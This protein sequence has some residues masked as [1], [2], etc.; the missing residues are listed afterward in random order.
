MAE[1][2]LLKARRART[3]ARTGSSSSPRGGTACAL[4]SDARLRRR[5]R[6]RA[7]GRDAAAWRALPRFEGRSSVRTWLYRVATNAWLDV[8]AKR[9]PAAADKRVDAAEVHAVPAAAGSRCGSSRIRTPSSSSR[10]GRGTGGPLRAPRE[11]RARVRRR[12]AAAPPASGGAAVARRARFSAREVAERLDMSVASANSAL[13]RARRRW[14]A[15]CPRRASRAP[16]ARSGTRG[17]PAGRAARRCDGRSDV[18]AVVAELTR[19]RPGRCRLTRLVPR[20]GARPSWSSRRSSMARPARQA[21]GEPAIG[22][23]MWDDEARLY[24]R[25]RS[26]ST[27]SGDRMA[28]VT[29]FKTG[30]SSRPSACQVIPE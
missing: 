26:T 15:G 17:S 27:R 2:R 18:D 28:A 13:N 5:R 6:G 21:N 8:A 22:C 3:R 25:R 24:S 1:Q 12:R 23:Y 7:A 30:G 16:C 11:R 9:H 20:C 29:A 14:R 4:L 19:T 10:T